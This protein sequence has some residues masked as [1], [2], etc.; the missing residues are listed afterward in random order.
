[1]LPAL[2]LASKWQKAKMTIRIA[3]RG[4]SFSINLFPQQRWRDAGREWD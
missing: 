1:M 3:A 4:F 2:L